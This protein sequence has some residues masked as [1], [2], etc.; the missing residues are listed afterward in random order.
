[1]SPEAERAKGRAVALLADLEE[2]AD[3]LVFEAILSEMPAKRLALKMAEKCVAAVEPA[4][5]PN[6]HK[7]ITDRLTIARVETLG[8]FRAW[9]VA[10]GL[11]DIPRPGVHVHLKEAA[12]VRQTPKIVGAK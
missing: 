1:M 8:A 7:A 6:N 9:R 5:T 10:L 2:E 4:N 3:V 11:P 12:K